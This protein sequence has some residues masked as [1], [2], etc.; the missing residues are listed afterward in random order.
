MMK[1]FLNPNRYKIMKKLSLFLSLL[2]LLFGASAFA[3]TKG[4]Y[5]SLFSEEKLKS[6]IKF[7]SDDKF[8]GRAPGSKGG[9][10]AAQYIADE[11]KKIGV[12]PA[13][14]GSYFQPVTLGFRQSESGN[15]FKCR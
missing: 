6:T 14:N 5:T 7:L 1:I 9:E 12:K 4:K 3:Q 13:N 2:I 11:L 15:D 8:E 10:A